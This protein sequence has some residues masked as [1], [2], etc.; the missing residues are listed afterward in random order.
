[1]SQFANEG[2]VE[3]EAFRAGNDVLLMPE[4]VL[5]AKE[6]LI[7]AYNKGIITEA[8]LSSSVKKILMAKYKAGLHNYQPIELEN[9]YEDLNSIENDL[10]Y[11]EA[12]ENAITVAKNNF[13]LLPIKKLENKKIAYVKF[14][15]DSGETFLET[16]S[17]YAKVTQIEAK[18]AAG[19][20]NNLKDF[21]LV[22][23]GFH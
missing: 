1:V 15:D 5:K 16:L 21:N 18:D 14:G 23:I 6:K 10:I 3:L 22:I 11:E 2:E 19:Y 13:S 9:L 20:R 7:E 12:M 8:H 17:M 4:N